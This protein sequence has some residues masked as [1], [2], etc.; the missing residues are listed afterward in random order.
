MTL[1]ADAWLWLALSGLVVV[2]MAITSCV[3]AKGCGVVAAPGDN[4]EMMQAALGTSP[5]AKEQQSGELAAG[6]WQNGQDSALGIME[7]STG[8]G[9]PGCAYGTSSMPRHLIDAR[10]RAIADPAGAAP[11]EHEYEHDEEF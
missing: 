10:R 5:A 4:C 7:T 9:Q 1:S 6:D 2:P 8:T 11:S 3:F